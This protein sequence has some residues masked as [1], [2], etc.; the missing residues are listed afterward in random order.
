MFVAFRSVPMNE[1]MDLLDIV[2]RL[3]K[4]FVEKA[5]VWD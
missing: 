1:I 2:E 5:I 3:V 4:V